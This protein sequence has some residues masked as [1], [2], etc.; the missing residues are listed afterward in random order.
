[1]LP[2]KPNSIRESIARRHRRMGRSM[3]GTAIVMEDCGVSGL[4]TDVWGFAVVHTG[5]VLLQLTW[6]A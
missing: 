6:W 1:M 4:K 3:L 2:M 5:A